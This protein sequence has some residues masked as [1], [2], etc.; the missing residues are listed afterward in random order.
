MYDSSRFLICF[1]R[2]L[3][4]AV[5]RAELRRVFGASDV[6]Q[7]P[8]FRGVLLLRNFGRGGELALL[9]QHVTSTK[10]DRKDQDAH[11]SRV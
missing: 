10:D 3:V 2:L 8:I 11:H 5:N 7:K 4:V 6:G 9:R 1:R